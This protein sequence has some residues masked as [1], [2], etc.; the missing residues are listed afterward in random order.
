MAKKPL[1]EL[2]AKAE[3]DSDLATRLIQNPSQ[4]KEEYELTDEQM[5]TIAGAGQHHAQHRKNAKADGTYE[6]ILAAPEIA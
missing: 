4:F 1:Q 5:A 2:L 3:K 6:I